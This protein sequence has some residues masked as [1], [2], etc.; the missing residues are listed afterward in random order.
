MLAVGDILLGGGDADHGDVHLAG[1]Q[2]LQR[3]AVN[4][5]Q[6]VL[7]ARASKAYD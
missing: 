6:A 2:E 1:L 4:I 7:N 5:S 3:V